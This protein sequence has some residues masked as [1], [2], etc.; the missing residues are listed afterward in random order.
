MEGYAEVFVAA[1]EPAHVQVMCRFSAAGN[2]DLTTRWYVAAV[3]CGLSNARPKTYWPIIAAAPRV[4]KNLRRSNATCRV[5]P[6]ASDRGGAVARKPA[7]SGILFSLGGIYSR[8]STVVLIPQTSTID[9][10][11]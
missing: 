6:S 2:D 7:R 3:I 5:L 9:L 4:Y 11:W 8:W 1:H 10:P